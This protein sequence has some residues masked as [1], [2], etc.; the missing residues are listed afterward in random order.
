MVGKEL[1][2]ANLALTWFRVLPQTYQTGGTT[3]LFSGSSDKMVHMY[4]AEVS[5]SRRSLTDGQ[6]GTG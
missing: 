5:G 1:K 3:F 4:E 6:L 2:R